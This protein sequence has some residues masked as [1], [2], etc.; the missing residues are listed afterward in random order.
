MLCRLHVG[1]LQEAPKN[2]SAKV[3][4]GEISA[5]MARI[6]ADLPGR[7]ACE[8]LGMH[9]GLSL[10]LREASE[11]GPE[12]QEAEAVSGGATRRLATVTV[13]WEG[14]QGGGLRERDLLREI[15]V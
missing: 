9:S 15:V 4:D 13:S 2:W 1:S 10:A 5:V 11:P 12:R 7:V 8:R 3:A 14:R 6:E